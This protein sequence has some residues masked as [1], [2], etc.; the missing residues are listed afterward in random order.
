[1]KLIMAI[2]QD[3]VVQDILLE[4]SNNDVRA[5]RLASTGGF[6]KKGNT[7]ILVGA[8][9]EKVEEIKEM[10]LNISKSKDPVD[11]KTANTV[12]FVLNMDK[13]IRV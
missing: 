11:E 13:L 1:M 10:I 3:H 2:I 12:M 6:F 4:L 8:E 7:T 9:D 5:T